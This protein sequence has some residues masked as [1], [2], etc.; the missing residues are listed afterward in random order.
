LNESGDPNIGVAEVSVCERM[1]VKLV[2]L[3]AARYMLGSFITTGFVHS[4]HVYVQL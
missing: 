2:T 4:L 1:S 3:P